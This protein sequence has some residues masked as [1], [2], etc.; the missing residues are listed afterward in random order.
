MARARASLRYDGDDHP[1]VPTEN[2]IDTWAAAARSRCGAAAVVTTE[3]PSP[4]DRG[5]GTASTGRGLRLASTGA[6]TLVLLAKG[7][8]SLGTAPIDVRYR[9]V[10]ATRYY[11]SSNSRARSTATF[12]GPCFRRRP[13]PAAARRAARGRAVGLGCRVLYKFVKS[14]IHSPLSWHAAPR[15]LRHSP[16]IRI[17]T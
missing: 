12:P 17:C 5:S 10:L 14:T 3:L 16:T 1:P 15:R 11:R 2:W 6:A 9:N 4:R 8:S 13:G 7:C